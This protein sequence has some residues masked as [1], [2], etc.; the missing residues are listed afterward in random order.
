MLFCAGGILA[1]VVGVIA[2]APAQA[3]GVPFG[4]AAFSGSASGSAIHVDALDNNAA[5]DV[6]RASSAVNSKGLTAAANDDAVNLPINPALPTKNAYARGKG[7]EA[8]GASI[9]DEAV[10]TA[11]P[12]GPPVQNEV[13]VPVSPLVY[14]SLSRGYAFARYNTDTC[15]LGSDL[16]GSYGYVAD[17]NV[18]E[19]GT[20][21]EDGSFQMPLV[22]ADTGPNTRDVVQSLARETLVPNSDG[23]FGLQSQVVTQ[24]A[25]ITLFKGTPDEL[26]ILVAG[27]FVLT[28]TATGIPG[29][30]TVTYRP[31]NA[32]ADPT[33]PIITVIQGGVESQ[34][35][36]F[37]DLL[38]DAGLSIPIPGVADISIA[39]PP[40]QT[41][42]ADGTTVA[43][44]ADVVRI[45]LLDGSL[46]NI[47]IGHAAVKAQV[48]AG[49]ITCPIP[50]TKQATPNIVNSTTAPDGK[51]LVAITI[52][53]AFDC[54][55]LNVSLE[56]IITRKSGDIQFAI[57]EDDPRN[58]PKKGPG[59]TFTKISNT[60][61]I[62]KYD[63]L[64]TLA[65]GAS[66]VVN[67]VIGVTGGSGEIQDI[68]TAKGT[69]ACAE[70]SALGQANVNLSGS[71]TLVTVVATVLPRTGGTAGLALIL[72]GTAIAA[73]VTRRVARTRRAGV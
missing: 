60:S 5:V 64:G 72:A 53:N 24:L 4:Q 54:P 65:P 1:A 51:F 20:S 56:D 48:P 10:A 41:I 13:A 16:A 68:A 11:P 44:T 22:A 12:N 8:L 55:L 6:G 62:A 50:V 37:Q 34:V 38:G 3:V 49:G 29:K 14:A 71:F 33:L 18:I 42:S 17:A 61:S 58:D 25:P 63:N 9:A 21:N 32:E 67:L 19:T 40:V 70:G 47:R 59:V 69:L 7:I 52:K 39:E 23:T 26:T 27:D 30:S 45:V 28:A 57:V 36:T 73:V 2:P 35:L 66:R 43:A 31:A 15:V 46:A